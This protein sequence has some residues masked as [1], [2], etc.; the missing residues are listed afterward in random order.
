MGERALKGFSHPVRSWRVQG[1]KTVGGRFEALRPELTEFVGRQIES[2]Q[3][4]AL[5]R[6][7]KKGHGYVVEVSGEAGIG[8]SRLAAEL[9]VEVRAR[10]TVLS[11]RCLPYGDGITFLPL[12]ELVRRRSSRAGEL[13]R[14]W[15]TLNARQPPAASSPGSATFSAFT[16]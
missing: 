13:K 2:L 6:N 16:K 4:E 14:R 9:Q 3:I 11:A 15:A 7:V 1:T 5:W 12:T 10:A 8:K